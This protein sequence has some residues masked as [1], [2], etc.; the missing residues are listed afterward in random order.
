M[1][2]TYFED[3]D[4]PTERDYVRF[5]VRDT[6]KGKGLLPEDANFED[7]EIDAFLAVEKTWQGAV[8]ACFEALEAAWIPNPSFTADG[9][10][11]SMSHVSANYGKAAKRWRLMYG[12]AAG[13]QGRAVPVIKVDGYS[14]DVSSIEVS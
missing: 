8:A 2:F 3:E 9:Y 12:G 11:V 13:A 6:T 10:A 1:S 14:Q 4:N 7:Y 5:T